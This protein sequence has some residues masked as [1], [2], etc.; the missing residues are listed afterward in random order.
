MKVIVIGNGPGGSAI[1]SKL[2]AKGCEVEQYSDE[3]VGFYSRIKLPS[4][5]GSI[6]KL[7]A[8]C[9]KTMPHYLHHGSVVGIH[10]ESKMVLLS[11]GETSTYDKLVLATGSNARKF[12]T[13]SGLKNIYT[14]RTYHDGIQITK[15]LNE[16][17]VVLGGGLLG[18]ETALAINALG[19]K[20]YV[21][22]G[23]ANL[24]ARQLNTEA[25]NIVEEK[26]KKR[27]NFDITCGI[28]A[29]KVDGNK[30]IESITLQDGTVINCN[31]LIIAAGVIPSTS[32]AKNCGLKIDSAIVV[33]SRCKTSDNDIYAI[34]DCAQYNGKCPGM[35]PVA[36][37]MANIASLDILGEGIDYIEPKQMPT[38]FVVDDLNIATFGE[39]KGQCLSKRKGEL[40][41]AWYIEDKKVVGVLLVGPTTHLPLAKKMLGKEVEDTSLLLDF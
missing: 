37:T 21:V 27:G 11:S 4:A 1:A 23:G 19:L 8:L 7:D 18:L 40:Y 2:D 14:L 39:K 15:S 16:P 17:V 30:N 38:R 35:I 34:G 10:K 31:T 25:A 24:L 29:S 26:C 5:L 41:E 12:Y 33:D 36:L 13:D 6:E 9:S 28:F 22:E 3:A 20:V 32:L